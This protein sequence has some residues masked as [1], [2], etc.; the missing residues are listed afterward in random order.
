VKAPSTIEAFE[1]TA[2]LHRNSIDVTLYR[3]VIGPW[4]GFLKCL[5]T[6]QLVLELVVGGSERATYG[7]ADLKGRVK[8][9]RVSV[10]RSSALRGSDKIEAWALW[11]A[12]AP[13]RVEWD[14]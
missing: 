9:H 2:I 13:H 11:G 7:K 4:G 5:D 3:Y 8:C 14:A 12:H 10:G 6:Y 1:W